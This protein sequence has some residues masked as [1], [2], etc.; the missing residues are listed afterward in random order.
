MGKVD[1]Q[2]VTAPTVVISPMNQKFKA[3]SYGNGFDPKEIGIDDQ[4]GSYD[5]GEGDHG[6]YDS[7]YGNPSD[8]G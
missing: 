6:W 7:G 4:R 1:Q 3:K 5:H 8:A 2:Q